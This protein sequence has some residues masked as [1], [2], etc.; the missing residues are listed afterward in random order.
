MSERYTALNS[1]GTPTD[2]YTG[3]VYAQQQIN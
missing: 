3:R 2:T 1:T